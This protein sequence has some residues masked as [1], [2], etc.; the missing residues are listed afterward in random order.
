[1]ITFFILIP[2]GMIENQ[3]KARQE[4]FCGVLFCYPCEREST[5]QRYLG[6]S[7]LRRFLYYL[8]TALVVKQ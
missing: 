6:I 7:G 4:F 8:N 1:M 3:G 5:V 2:V